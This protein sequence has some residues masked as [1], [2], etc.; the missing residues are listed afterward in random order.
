MTDFGPLETEADAI[1]LPAVAAIYARARESSL[2]GAMSAGN[3]A[4]MSAALEAAGVTLGAYEARIFLGWMPQWEPHVVGVVAEV[5]R[6]A[7]LAGLTAAG[8]DDGDE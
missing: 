4:M 3:L 6:R 8:E 2:P 7:H 1:A 5:I